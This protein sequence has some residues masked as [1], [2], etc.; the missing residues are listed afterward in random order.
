MG[1]RLFVELRDQKSLAYAVGSIDAY[2]LDPGYIVLYIGTAPEK[3]KIAISEFQRV[4]SEIQA[5]GVTEEEV[6][7]AKRYILGV[8]EI[9][10]Q[11]TW[12][13]TGV[14]ASGERI[15]GSYKRYE[16]DLQ[17]ISRVTPS[18]V[19]EVTK[20]YLREAGSV[21]VILRGERNP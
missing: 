16:E 15:F 5:K 17:G 7:R 21:R 18:M 19:Q 2:P 6:E 14:Y 1:G 20:K 9:G 11:S 13:R 8:T 4:I 10:L 3:E 12:N